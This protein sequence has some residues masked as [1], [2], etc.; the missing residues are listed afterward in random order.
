MTGE[1]TLMGGRVRLLQGRGGYR[2]AIDPVLLAASIAAGSGQHVLELGSGGGA[3]AL[4]L[5]VRIPGLRVTGL[6]LQPDLA[7]LARRSAELN[8]LAGR[9]S[10]IAGDI[11]S[12]PPGLVA[13]SFD[14]VMANPPYQ[15]AGSGRPPLDPGRAA[16]NVEGPAGLGRWIDCGLRLVRNKGRLS[17]IHRADRIDRIIAHMRGQAGAI[18]VTPLWPMPGKAAKRVIVQCRKGV[19]SPAAIDPGLVLHEADGSYTAAAESI[20]R[21]GAALGS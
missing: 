9:V 17:I 19:A 6:E 20:L 12:P 11:L 21:D 10:F 15:T 4:C 1:D 7:E 16:A 5:A 8:G 14:H 18:I 3:A 13:G 2:A